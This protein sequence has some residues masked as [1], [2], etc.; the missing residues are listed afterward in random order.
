[1]G[2]LDLGYNIQIQQLTLILIY[3]YC[4]LRLGEFDFSNN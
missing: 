4:P 1:M 2:F 3:H